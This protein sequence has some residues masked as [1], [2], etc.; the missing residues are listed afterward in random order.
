[1]TTNSDQNKTLYIPYISDHGYVV[2]AA[3][4]A[5]G[6]SAEQLPPSDDETMAMGV[7]LCRGRECLPCFTMIGDIV[8]L[9]QRPDFVQEKAQVMELATCGPCR[10]GQ[11]LPLHQ[12]ILAKKGFS[13]L[14]FVAPSAENNYQ[15]FGD[16]P[17]RLRKLI[18]EGFVAVDLLLK[19]LHSFRPYERHLGETDRIY[20]RCLDEIVTAVSDGGGKKLDASM[21]KTAQ[22]FEALS[23]DVRQPRP[24]IGFVGEIYLRLNAFSN[25]DVIRKVEAAGGEVV[26]ASLIEMLYFNNW[27]VKTVAKALG[28]HL[29]AFLLAVSNRY[30]KVRERS[31]AKPVRHLLKMPYETAMEDLLVLVAPHYEPY[32]GTEAVLTIGKAIEYAHAGC[33]GILN[34][35]PFTCMPGLVSAGIAPGFRPGL[36]NIPWLDVSYDAQQGTNLNTRLEA[37]MYQAV[38]FDRARNG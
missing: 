37:F 30:Q 7:N 34:V 32:L 36:H 8:R 35:M 18:W 28:S 29:S 25:Q 11:Y 6:L 24:L 23:V 12:S 26:M 9:T 19:L 10:L 17:L 21:I 20:E 5:Q 27:G 31:L 14:E 16:K 22:R 33:A 13:D 2:A 15:G 4:Q 38:E 1:V 3:M